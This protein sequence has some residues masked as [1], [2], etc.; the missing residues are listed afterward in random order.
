MVQQEVNRRVALEVKKVS[1]DYESRSE[2][3]LQRAM[4]EQKKQFEFD[5]RAD[6]VALE[7]NYTVLQK[8]MNHFYMASS[9]LPGVGQ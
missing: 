1:A 8:K 4:T 5:R 3:K 7:A 9:E 6:M 2:V